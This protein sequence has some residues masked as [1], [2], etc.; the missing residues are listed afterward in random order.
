[1]S[2]LS[3]AILATMTAAGLIGASAALA[4]SQTPAQ[5]EQ[6]MMQGQGMQGG[7]MQGEAT[8]GMPMM[9]MMQQMQQMMES[10]NQMMQAMT[11]NTEQGQKPNRG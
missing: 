11:L 7:M 3:K 9:G 1:M 5:P 10:C 8:Q 6:G 4:Q 2:K